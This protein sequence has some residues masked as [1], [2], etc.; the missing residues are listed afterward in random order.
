MSDFRELDFL[1]Y[2]DY[3]VYKHKIYKVDWSLEDSN[4]AIRVKDGSVHYIDEFERVKWLR[5]YKN[6]SI[7]R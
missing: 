3:F 2:D 4:N 7:K 5:N 6:L 1:K